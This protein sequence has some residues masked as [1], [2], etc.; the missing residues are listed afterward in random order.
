[1]LRQTNGW[2]ALHPRQALP[3]PSMFGRLAATTS[4]IKMTC[5]SKLYR[6]VARPPRPC[7]TVRPEASER[8]LARASHTA[9]TASYDATEPKK[10]K[11]T[12]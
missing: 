3:P 7:C 9:P 1:M 4:P 12:R 5:K 2:R 10:E 6:T 8:G 11:S